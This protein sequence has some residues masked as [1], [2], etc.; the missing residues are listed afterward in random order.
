MI[1]G[2]FVGWISSYVDQTTGRVLQF[3][4]TFKLPALAETLRQIGRYGVQ[5]FYDGPIGDQMID[6]IQLRGGM[7]TNEDLRQY[8]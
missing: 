3:G 7:L 5:V 8:R 4:D 2:I 6:D 1:T